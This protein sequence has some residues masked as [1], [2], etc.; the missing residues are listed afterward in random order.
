MS[1]GQHTLLQHFRQIVSLASISYTFATLHTIQY[2]L[3]DHKT[4]DTTS[5][6]V[7]SAPDASTATSSNNNASTTGNSNKNST[8]SGRWSPNEIQLLLNY[9]EAHCVLTTP[10]G[11]NLKKSDFT[12]AHETIK[13]KTAA[14]CHYKW[15]NVSIF[16]IQLVVLIDYLLS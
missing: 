11:L 2:S 3:C 15:G 9:V 1:D 8:S 12:K 10:R 16:I 7:Q 4:D 6:M 5:S 14:Q 13:T